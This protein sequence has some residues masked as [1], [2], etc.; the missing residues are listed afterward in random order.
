MKVINTYTFY[1]CEA[2]ENIDIPEN[3]LTISQGVFGYDKNLKTLNILGSKTKMDKDSIGTGYWNVNDDGI[4]SGCGQ[5][6][7]RCPKDSTAYGNYVEFY[8]DVENVVY[9]EFLTKNVS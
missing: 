2:L 8:E 5:L 3:I 6:V 7:I 4:L 1:K 9:E